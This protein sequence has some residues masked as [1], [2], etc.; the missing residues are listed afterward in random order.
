MSETIKA[1]IEPHYTP[2][3]IADLWKVHPE[4]V[5]RMFK[6]EAGVL[7]IGTGKKPGKQAR[8]T[9]RIPQ[10]VLDRVHLRRTVA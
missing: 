3:E 9:I 10:S 6:E 1:A 5:R 8:T 7:M 4:S 2:E